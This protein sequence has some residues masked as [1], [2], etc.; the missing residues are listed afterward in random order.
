ML[1]VLNMKPSI[2]H[3][4]PDILSGVPVFRGTRVPI[5][6]LFDYLPQEDHSTIMH[7][8]VSNAFRQLN[9]IKSH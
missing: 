7:Q 4:D 5:E 8:A 6:I 9:A 3:T 1:K 2:I